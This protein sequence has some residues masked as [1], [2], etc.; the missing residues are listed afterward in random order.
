MAVWIVVAFF[1]LALKAQ[2]DSYYCTTSV[3]GGALYCCP[4]DDAYD[5]E[6][7][8]CAVDNGTN[9]YKKIYNEC[10]TIKQGDGPSNNCPGTC[11][12]CRHVNTRHQCDSTSVAKGSQVAEDSK[13]FINSDVETNEASTGK[14]SMSALPALASLLLIASV[15]S[16]AAG[17]RYARFRQQSRNRDAAPFNSCAEVE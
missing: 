14:L 8:A 3:Y 15:L 6:S 7:E 4:K 13:L 12:C 16:F 5:Y 2:A 17:T 10:E 1:M 9:G 11:R